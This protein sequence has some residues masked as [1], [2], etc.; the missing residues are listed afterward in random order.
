MTGEPDP[1]FA[2]LY[3]VLEAAQAVA[4]QS[5]VL[6]LP[7]EAVDAAGRDPIAEAGYGDAFIHRIGHGIGIEEHED[8][9]IVAGNATTLAA[10]HAFS[11]EP[12]IYLAGRF[13]ARYRGHRRRHRVP[14]RCAATWPTTRSTSSRPDDG[15]GARGARRRQR[16][17]RR[18]PMSVVADDLA[19]DPEGPAE[20]ST[21]GIDVGPVTDWLAANV[22]LVPPL[23]FDLVAGGRSNLTFKVTDAAG[24]VR[25]AAAAADLARAADR[26]RHARE[27]RVITALWPTPVPVARTLGLCL[28][29]DV[30]GAP[31]YVMEFVRRQRAARR[32]H[33]RGGARPSRPPA[34]ER[35]ARRGA[36]RPA[37]RSTSTPSASA[38]SAGETGYLARQLKRWHTQFDGSQVEGVERA[39]VVDRVWERLCRG[40]APAGRDGN[41]AR[42][43]P[44]RQH[45]AGATTGPWPPCST[46]R[47]ARSAIRSP[48]SDC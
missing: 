6:G 22:G 20:H 3:A 34:G 5:A 26:A 33:R 27:H 29:P 17:R 11:V 13:G 23:A 12:G 1:E 44:A 36:R 14:A 7:C 24:D 48:T 39:S 46:G 42:R 32:R 30:N 47:S 31:F 35:V 2:A 8:P 19:T 41:R 40:G 38:T 43:L 25:R 45:D 18:H 28:D 37:C 16:R 15:R 4:V 21:E 10:G 9:Y